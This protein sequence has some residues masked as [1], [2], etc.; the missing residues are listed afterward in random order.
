MRTWFPSTP[1]ESCLERVELEQSCGVSLIEQFMSIHP[2]QFY[3]T[4]FYPRPETQLPTHPQ[5]KVR[6]RNS[7]IIL[8][9]VPQSFPFGSAPRVAESVVVLGPPPLNNQIKSFGGGGGGGGAL[10]L[11]CEFN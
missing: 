3:P 11:L 5:S 4:I 10:G 2:P 9:L 7:I 8:P 1:N 6:C